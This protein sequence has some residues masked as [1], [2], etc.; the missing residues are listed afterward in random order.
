MYCNALYFSVIL[1]VGYKKIKALRVR[2]NSSD[3]YKDKS[4]SWTKMIKTI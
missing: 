3:I 4:S 1:I 2:K